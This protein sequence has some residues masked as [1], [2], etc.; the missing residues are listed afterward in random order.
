MRCCKSCKLAGGIIPAKSLMFGRRGG[1]S[2]AKEKDENIR[3]AQKTKAKSITLRGGI[4]LLHVAFAE[5]IKL[6]IL[7]LHI[8]G[9]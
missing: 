5:F 1:T 2:K 7:R 8:I 3:I 6:N 9:Q 4:D